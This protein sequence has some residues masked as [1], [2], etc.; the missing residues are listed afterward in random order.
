MGLNT[1][2]VD[3]AAR[4]GYAILKSTNGPRTLAEYASRDIMS[5][6]YYEA[7]V[8]IKAYLEYIEKHG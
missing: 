2:A 7:E 6:R 8:I 4:E 3:Y 5:M 1:E